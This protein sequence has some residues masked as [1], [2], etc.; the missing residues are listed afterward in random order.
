VIAPRRPRGGRRSRAD[1]SPPSAAA[2][3]RRLLST[4]AVQAAWPRRQG[5]RRR[6]RRARKARSGES[7]V[8]TSQDL[9]ETKTA[10]R[11]RPRAAHDNGGRSGGRGPNDR[12]TATGAA[13]TGCGGLAPGSAWAAA[14]GSP[15]RRLSSST[16]RTACSGRGRGGREDAR[17]DLVPRRRGLP[18]PGPLLPPRRRHPA[19]SPT[20]PTPT[21]QPMPAPPPGPCPTPTRSATR[22]PCPRRPRCPTP[23]P[24]PRLLPLRRPAPLPRLD[25]RRARAPRPDPP[26]GSTSRA[27]RRG[28]RTSRTRPRPR[29]GEGHRVPEPRRLGPRPHA[30]RLL[31]RGDGPDG[32]DSGP[33]LPQDGDFFEPDCDF[34]PVPVPPGGALEGETAT[35]ARATAT[36]T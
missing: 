32:L 10:V 22:L 9:V 21:P 31:D 8:Y 16:T 6:S 13:T 5:R 34:A 12:V 4:W 30:D 14:A 23:T 28:T 24:C 7:R 2:R 33:Q 20:A 26:R 18:H 27:T 19:H 1:A 25:P 17:H 15:A 11:S 29:L 36:A 35:S 3:R